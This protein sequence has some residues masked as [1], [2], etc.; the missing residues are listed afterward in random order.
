MPKFGDG[1]S[2]DV[3]C[4]VSPISFLTQRGLQYLLMDAFGTAVAI[5]IADHIHP[6]NIGMRKYSE[7]WCA[8]KEH[9]RN[10]D[11]KGGQSCRFGSTRYLSQQKLSNE[12]EASYMNGRIKFKSNAKKGVGMR[13]VHIPTPFSFVSSAS[14]ATSAVYPILSR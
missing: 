12:L 10:Y 8:I 13:Y 1:E 4:L 11:A 2:R 9:A 14:S 7:I 6:V 5:A 3:T